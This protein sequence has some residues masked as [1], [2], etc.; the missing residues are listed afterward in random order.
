MSEWDIN[1]FY[2]INHTNSNKV[3]DLIMPFMTKKGYI[4]LLPYLL[5]IFYNA[6]KGKKS[7]PSFNIQFILWSI[8]ISAM[9]FLL[10]DWLGYEIKNLIK[11]TR[12]CNVLEDVRLLVGCSKS[13]SMPSSHAAN[14]MAFATSLFYLNRKYI[15]RF[16]SLYP[17]FLAIIISY[18]RVYVGVHYPS[19]VL[20]GMIFGSFIAFLTINF[21]RYVFILFK[22]RPYETVLY[23]FLFILSIFRVYYIL[24]GPIDL[25]PD[26]A[27]YWEW[28]RR[29]DLSYYSKGPMVAYLILLG[30]SFLGD[31]V[32]GIRIMAV[33]FSSL[34]SI[35]LF[36]LVRAMNKDPEYKELYSS[37]ALFS[38]LLLQ[39]IPLFSPFGVIFTIDSPFVFFWILSLYFFCKA[40]E[41]EK[42][43][44][45]W[46]GLL[47]I[48][49]GLGLLTKYTM[50]F[51]F[52]CAFLFLIFSKKRYILKK[53]MPYLS[54]VLSL[55]LFSPVIFWNYKH[56]WVTLKHTAGQAHLSS[57]FSINLQTFFEFIGSQIGVI[58]PFI[59]F[60]MLYAIIKLKEKEKKETLFL[61]YFSIPVIAFF[62]LKSLHAKVQ[63]NW[64]MTGY[65]TAII[66]FSIFYLQGNPHKKRA[67]LVKKPKLLAL[68]ITVPL[69]ITIFA[70]YPSILNL[71]IKLDPSARLRGWKELGE[72][73]SRIY[74]ELSEKGEVLLFSDRYQV[75]SE[76]A[77][78]V[79]GQPRTFCIN[80]GR[81]M[82][83]YD[84]W[85]DINSE[86]KKIRA[87]KKNI[88]IN[89]I[90]VRTGD[91]GIPQN[92]KEAF[93]N[94]EKRPFKVLDKKKRL[95]REYSIFICYNFKELKESLPDK[96]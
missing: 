76:L 86:A 40:L 17:I 35:F 75:S 89:G 25:S 14:S 72:E 2:F 57:S 37:R 48:S 26:E 38:A 60:M 65:I 66:A 87:L 80:N 4:L 64:A 36:K 13:Y 50:A 61:F 1:L 84:L 55:I 5:Y 83:Q 71:P 20:V 47:G 78:Y 18:S 43:T 23:T 21:F 8:F 88:L 68:A 63:A 91:R 79:K 16:F 53:P 34:S 24:H 95:I 82:N 30:T 74:E 7:N 52:I 12:P 54:L 67:F 92:V 45:L 39:I 29:P 3:F 11:R 10:S 46:W 49:I 94:C 96:F 85:P 44:T 33:I 70:H 19:D 56:G 41:I 51:F 77:F 31:N 6:Y 27:H 62:I 42:R 58:T 22:K 90:Y 81:R 28:S 93:Y 73:I 9:A 15:N 59:F 32:I 69:L